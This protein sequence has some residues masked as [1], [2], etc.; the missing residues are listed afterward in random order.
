MRTELG[1]REP[2]LLVMSRTTPTRL[3]NDSADPAELAAALGWGAVGATANPVIAL[4]ALRAG[5]PRWRGRVAEL[6]QLSPAAAAHP[7]A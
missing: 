7:S 3:W 2:P 1:T 6:A 4:A 5:G